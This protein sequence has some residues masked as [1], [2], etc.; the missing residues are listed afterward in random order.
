MARTKSSNTWLKEHFAD[1]YVKLAHEKGYRARS[2][3]KLLE[4]NKKDKLIKPGML[5]VD[6]G[7]APGG[8][9]Q[10]AASLIGERGKIIA[11]DI[12]PMEPLPKVH[13]IEGDFRQEVVIEQLKTAL[14][15]QPLDLV[16]SDIAPNMSGT[17]F[18]DQ[19]RA[20]LL[21]E[22]ALEFAIQHL[23]MNGNFLVKVFQGEGFDVYLRKM[24]QHF[25]KVISRK[26]EASRDRSRELY[27]LGIGLK[28]R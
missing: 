9:S 10:V 16:L 4:L 6:L 18:I 27:L 14:D 28:M 7:A 1:H 3:F 13:I 8:W 25:T 15:N 21:S 23:K 11:L 22:L 19:P 17:A 24:R 20:M 12:L 5:I 2:A 26:P